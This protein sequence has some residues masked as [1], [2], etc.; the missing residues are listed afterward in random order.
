M[1]TGWL[2]APWTAT[3]SARGI[4]RERLF[5]GR[6]LP[7]RAFGGANQRLDG[8][9]PEWSGESQAEHYRH[10]RKSSIPVRRKITRHPRPI[11]QL[12]YQSQYHWIWF[13]NYAAFYY[14][15]VSLIFIVFK[16]VCLFHTYLFFSYICLFSWFY[17]FVARNSCWFRFKWFRYL[18]TVFSMWIT[19]FIEIGFLKLCNQFNSSFVIIW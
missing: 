16:N 12:P 4:V 7:S 15:Y 14:N 8:T 19:T 1:L 6:T 17:S 18:I 5:A 10:G 13:W 11:R 3:S 2:I 9:A